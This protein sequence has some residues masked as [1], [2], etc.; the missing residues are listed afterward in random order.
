MKPTW[1]ALL[2][3]IFFS[4]SVTSAILGQGNCTRPQKGETT[5]W[6][7]NQHPIAFEE[8]PYRK[9]FG[10]VE[11]PGG[12]PI[13]GVLVEVF[14]H[15]EDTPQWMSDVTEGKSKQRKVAAC[16]TGTD[17][18][19]WF[20]N[21]APGRYEVRLSYGSYDPTTVFD[22]MSVI[23]EI[24]PKKGQPKGISVWMHNAT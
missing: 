7:G 22:V 4:I 6:E 5:H 3:V 2:P 12:G 14:T 24:D 20:S 1:N 18:K 16:R 13:K 21:L 10:V 8:K 15:P 17:G 9:L 11:F 19:F 23:V